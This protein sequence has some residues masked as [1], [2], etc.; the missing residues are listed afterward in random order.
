M[1]NQVGGN[2]GLIFDG[3][4][5][6]IRPD[7]ELVVIGLEHFPFARTW[8]SS[9][10]NDASRRPLTETLT[11]DEVAEMWECSGSGNAETT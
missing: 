6:A 7:G 5:L 8:W 3:S 9:T 2:D 10:P 11:L 1:T 4:S